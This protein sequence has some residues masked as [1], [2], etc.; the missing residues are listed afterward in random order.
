MNRVI[1]KLGIILLLSSLFTGMVVGQTVLTAGDIAIIGFNFDNPDELGFV[2]L[3]DISTST[4]IKFTDNGWFSSGS[5]RSG[6]GTHTWTAGSDYSAG[7]VITVTTSGPAFSSSGDQII[8]YQGDA[9]S[10]TLIFALNSE[11]SSWQ[12]DATS[13][14]TSALP[15]GLTDGTNA[16]ALAEADNGYYSGITS[17][18]Q[19]DLLTAICNASNW[20]T[21]NSRITNTSWVFSFTV[22]G[23]TSAPDDPTSFTAS[24]ASASQIDLSWTNNIAGNEVMIVYD[25]DNTFTDPVDGTSYSGS[26]LGGTVIYQNTTESFSHTGLTAGTTYYY[27]AWSNDAGDDLY[28]AGVIANA[29]TIKAEPTNHPSTFASTSDHNSITLTWSDND[30]AV[31]A[32]GYLIKASS[33]SLESISPAVDGTAEADDTDWSDNAAIMNL[34]HGAETCEFTGLN[35][36]TTYY[37]TIWAYTN[38]ASNI[39]YQTTRP[40][41]SQS[42]ATTVAPAAPSYALDLDFETLGGYTTSVTEFGLDG[43]TYF[44]RTDGSDVTDSFTN[45]QGSYFFAAQDIDGNSNTPPL[46]LTIEDVDISGYTDLEFSIYL[47][48]GDD[49]S[50]QDW[51]SGDYL[52][53]TYDIDNSGTFSNLMWI[54]NDGT[55]YNTAPQI[56]TDFDGNGDGAEITSIFSEHTA[57]ITGTGSTVDIKIEFSGLTSSDEDIALDNIRISGTSGATAVDAPT[58]FTAS[59]TSA[60]Q[61]AL[62][63]LQNSNMDNVIIVYDSD[64]SFTDPVDGTSYSGSA[65]GGTIIYNG[66]ATSYDHVGLD[67]ATQYYYKAWSIDGSNNYSAGVTNNTTTIKAEPSNH[68]STFTS[69][70]DHNSISVTWADNDGAILSDAYLIKASSTSFLAI[71]APLDATSESDDTDLSDGSAI[72]NVTHGTE[73]YQFTGLNAETTYY[74][75]IWPY[76]NS[77]SNINYKT[78]GTVPSQSKATTEA[79]AAPIIFISEVADPSDV[80]NAKFVE[81]YNSGGSTVDL[82][83]GS[84]YL[85]IQAN[86]GNYTNIALSGSI[87]PGGTYVIANNSTD[88][89]TSFTSKVADQYSGSV[90]GNGDDAYLLYSNG[91]QSSGTLVDIYGVIDIDGSGQIWEYLDGHAERNSDISEPNTTWTASEWTITSGGIAICTPTEHTL[92]VS[93]VDAP[94]SFI[95]TAASA[96][97]INLSWTK[98]ANSN[99][100]MIVFDSDGS[101]TNPVDGTPYSISASA[102]GGTIIY[103]GSET[104]FNH[105][106]L[107]GG[108]AYYYKAWSVDESNNYSTGITDNETT[109]KAEP[110]N[111]A[112]D[113][114]SSSNHSSITLSWTDNDGVIIADG[115]LIKASSSS[116]D[117]IS[118]PSDATVESNDSDISD[119]VAAMNIQSGVGTYTWTSLSASTTYYFKIFPYTNSASN[120]NYKTDG[121]VASGTETTSA[122]IKIIITEIMINPDSV[123][124]LNGEWFE[125]YNAGTETVNINGWVLSDKGTDSHTISNGG[126]LNIASEEYLVLGIDTNRTTNGNYPCNYK[127]TNFSLSNGGDEIIIKDGST[128]IDSISYDDG[129]NWPVPTGASAVF[130][131]TPEDDNDLYINWE[132]STLRLDNFSGTIGDKGSPGT[133]SIIDCVLNIKLFLEGGLN[134]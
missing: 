26:A 84:W 76:S 63:W 106:S 92:S 24:A 83:T 87:S 67:G 94:D 125:I 110:S 39:D 46:Y 60:S 134:P 33:V 11:L 16:I 30:G 29:T 88:F 32:D 80:A 57:S 34:V 97:Q 56:D 73:A 109:V 127:Y 28:S 58:S 93:S 22:S 61:I 48:E 112:S 81:L 1:K 43:D 111:Q 108:T 82:S 114:L 124:D 98:N 131:G 50:N 51:D 36:E 41:V 133:S 25:T 38:S 103:N 105:S 53:I 100:V 62:S 101:F 65:L 42:K 7:D 72:V 18:T 132:A 126:T 69:T 104:S 6:E 17:G 14:T 13:S 96:S 19:S 123:S 95:A 8:A 130:I 5:F 35:A 2:A 12:S 107:S 21:N 89:E 121:L 55:T 74:F 70:S 20:T 122:P 116:L 90:S 115:F 79:P 129:T 3:T 4:V 99:N 9:S 68:V 31:V 71:T 66:S 102:C 75:K 54:E 85:T 45:P 27:K 44:E 120:I 15:T 49:G 10:P 52:H 64:G 113:F 78:D 117:A 91:N 86:G 23:G 59:A 77:G 47:A 128:V 37:F 119:G 40:L 118:A